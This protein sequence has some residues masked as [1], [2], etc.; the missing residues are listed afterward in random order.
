MM[1]FDWAVVQKRVVLAGFKCKQGRD[2]LG[3]T[4]ELQ[5]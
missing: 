1:L 2:V 3:Y 5:V 4:M